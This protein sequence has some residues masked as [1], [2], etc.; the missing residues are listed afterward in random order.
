[1][2]KVF[3]DIGEVIDVEASYNNELS[4]TRAGNWRLWKKIDGI[5]LLVAGQF[6]TPKITSILIDNKK[7]KL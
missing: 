6:D 5:Y 4:Y 7:I 1:M 2:V 3:L